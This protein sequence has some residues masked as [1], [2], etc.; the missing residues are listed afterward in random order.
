MIRTLVGTTL[1]ASPEILELF[2]GDDNSYTEKSDIW[3]LGLILYLM[4]HYQK[5]QESAMKRMSQSLPW[6]GKSPID[7][8]N[9][10]KNK[11]LEFHCEKMPE[12]IK[13]IVRKMLTVDV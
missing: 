4:F 2:V 9:N 12:E 5:N 10:I 13:E 11:P 7:I 8:L 6:R 1:F 3:S